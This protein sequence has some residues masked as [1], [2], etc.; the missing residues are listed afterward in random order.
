MSV[1]MRM[2]P[3]PPPPPPPPGDCALQ[4]AHTARHVNIVQSPY[5]RVYH[6]RHPVRLIIDTGATTN[7]VK[8][9]FAR[10]IGLPVSAASQMAHQADRVIPLNVVCKVHCYIT[11]KGKQF[12]LDA[13]VVEGLDVEVFAGCPFM[14]TNDI[15]TRPDRQQIVID[16]SEIVYYVSQFARE[17]A[18][19]RTQSFLLRNA[20]PRQ[21]VLPG[22]FMEL[23]T[24]VHVDPDCAW[25][26]ER[27]FCLHQSICVDHG[28]SSRSSGCGWIIAHTK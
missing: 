14:V 11:R 2:P 12:E 21:V 24:P 27:M 1:V 18:I 28:P 23:S 17:P 3:P 6:G 26:L 7:M 8:G 13:L 5:L 22:E 19:R 15:A 25:A 4:D 10:C 20:G 16:G 9:S